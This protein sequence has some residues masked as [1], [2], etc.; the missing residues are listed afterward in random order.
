MGDSVDDFISVVVR[1]RPLLAHEIKRRSRG[2]AKVLPDLSAVEVSVD[3]SPDFS[4]VKQFLFNYCA[5]PNTS[6][7]E[8]FDTCGVTKLLNFTL[9]GYASTI[10]A[11]GQTGSGKT[12]SISGSE[13]TAAEGAVGAAENGSI[14][15][16]TKDGYGLG[17]IPRSIEYLFKE[18]DVMRENA[19]KR[20]VFDYNFYICTG[21]FS[22]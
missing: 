16:E 15:L 22:Q 7:K 11:Y 17:V 10:F 2:I 12:Y 6:Q 13:T 3:S 18:M 9:E 20:L 14:I 8:F 1:L 19:L 21:V 4:D 5:G